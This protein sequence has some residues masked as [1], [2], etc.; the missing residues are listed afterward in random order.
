MVNNPDEPNIYEE[1]E[2][3]FLGPV[4]A[5]IALKP[6][7]V[8]F[9]PGNHDVSQKATAAWA[10]ERVKMIAALPKQA[11]L[12]KH[13]AQAPTQAYLKELNA[14]SLSFADKCGATWKSPLSHVYD[15]PNLGVSFVA[16]STAFGCGIEGSE[17]DRGKLSIRGVAA[18]DAFQQVPE[19]ADFRLTLRP[20]LPSSKRV[21]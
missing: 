1:L 2:K 15:F 13:L 7:D 18:L 20:I 10:T 4:L 5:T 9:C 17:Y 6:S 12:E 3:N 21:I 8:I 14:G 11:E 16:L 19:A